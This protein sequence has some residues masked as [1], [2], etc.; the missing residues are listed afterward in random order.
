[1]PETIATLEI[2]RMNKN[3][4]FEHEKCHTPFAAYFDA[5]ISWDEL[6][7]KCGWE[8]R[9]DHRGFPYWG[10]REDAGDDLD[11]FDPRVIVT[12]VGVIWCLEPGQSGLVA[13][14]IYTKYG[15]YVVLNHSGDFEAAELVLRIE[16]S[17]EEYRAKKENL[18]RKERF[19]WI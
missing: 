4:L 12:E 3:T 7:T 2:Y 8:L 10:K 14:R 19:Y 5:N 16:R 11:R 15:A 6:L 17:L 1:L 18:P 13:D 9:K